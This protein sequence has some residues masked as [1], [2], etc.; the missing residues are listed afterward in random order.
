MPKVETLFYSG[1]ARMCSTTCGALSRGIMGISLG[2]GRSKAGEPVQASSMATHCVIAEVEQA[3]GTRDC[4][5][6]L[7][8]ELGTPK[9]QAT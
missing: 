8:C 7:G 1:V 6:Q 5:V 9:G 4:H 3:F 2:L